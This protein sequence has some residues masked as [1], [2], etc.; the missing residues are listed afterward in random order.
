MVKGSASLSLYG[1]FLCVLLLGGCE[2]TDVPEGG[3]L[4]IS[5]E[6]EKNRYKIGSSVKT[7][8]KNEAEMPISYN[9]C[10]SRLIHKTD[11]EWKEIGSQPLC[12]SDEKSLPPG[13]STS[14][15]IKLNNEMQLP[16]GL[17]KVKTDIE[18]EEERTLTTQAF[19]IQ[20]EGP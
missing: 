14:Y 13:D 17:Y 5:F 8:L 4:N 1:I 19:E 15:H 11:D 2:V 12:T 18:I 3:P 20:A 16:E 7:M 6:V 9:L 10:F